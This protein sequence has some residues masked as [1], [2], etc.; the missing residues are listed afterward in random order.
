MSWAWRVRDVGKQACAGVTGQQRSDRTRLLFSKVIL[1]SGEE[2]K[3]VVAV[4]GAG[5][6]DGGLAGEGSGS[7]EKWKVGDR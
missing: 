2:V 1:A 6:H 5:V 7:A 3:G 4:E